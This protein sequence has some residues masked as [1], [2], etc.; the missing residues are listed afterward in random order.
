MEQHRFKIHGFLLRSLLLIQL[1]YSINQNQFGMQASQSEL[2]DRM[3]K[4]ESKNLQQ[5]K[6]IAL[7]KIIAVEDRK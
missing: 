4:I 1:V 5:E 6:E 7:L 3:L 2:S